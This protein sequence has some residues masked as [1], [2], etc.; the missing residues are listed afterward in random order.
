V[1]MRHVCAVQLYR[2]LGI[3]GRY[4]GNVTFLCGTVLLSVGD[5]WTVLR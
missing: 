5:L 4:C 1:V 3:S 2:V